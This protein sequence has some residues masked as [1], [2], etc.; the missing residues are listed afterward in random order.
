MNKQA[1]DVDETDMRSEYDF[2]GG[3]R[4]KYAA[5]L[6]AEGYTIREYNTDGT[7]TETRV[8]GE[9]T[10]T[11]APD[12]WE[13][14]PSSQAVNQALRTLISLSPEKRATTTKPTGATPATQR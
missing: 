2:G 13:Y 5:T 10:I 8:L 12:V 4:G 11:I 6:R 14:F 1:S 9:N 3:V 7:F